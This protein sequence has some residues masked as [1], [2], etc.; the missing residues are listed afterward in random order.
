MGECG[1]NDD[2]AVWAK[3]TTTNL[4]KT[5]D[6]DHQLMY[7]YGHA[8]ALQK[9]F[10]YPRDICYMRTRFALNGMY[11]GKLY[12]V[13]SSMNY[14]V[15]DNHPHYVEVPDK[16]VRVDLHYRGFALIEPKVE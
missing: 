1:Y 4:I 3:H 16:H 10:I 15:H 11:Q 9:F 13:I 2:D 7:S 8:G 14:S 5:F 6:I 12:D